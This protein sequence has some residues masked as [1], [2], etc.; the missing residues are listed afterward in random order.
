MN[1]MN[2]KYELN[3]VL[4]CLQTWLDIRSKEQETPKI[5]ILCDAM[6][7]SL[8]QRLLDNKEPFFKPP[9]LAYSYPW[10]DLIE[11]KKATAEITF[12]NDVEIVVNQ[13]SNQWTL[14]ERVS[15]HE[16]ILLCKT[17]NYLYKATL[18]G[19]NDWELE[20]IP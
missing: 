19:P 11:N 3:F 5:D 17:N 7:S 8:L 4:N 10:Y 2:N 15:A 14:K 13:N 12:Y 18:I 1:N 9:P 6:H 20:L 16:L